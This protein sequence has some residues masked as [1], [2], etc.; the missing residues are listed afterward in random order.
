MRAALDRIVQR[1]SVHKC[2]VCHAVTYRKATLCGECLE[3]YTAERFTECRFCKMTAPVCV[4]STR[5]LYFCREL[6]LTM[7]SMFFYA[8]ENPTVKALIMSL[9]YA[10]DDEAE[11][12]LSR[13][14]AREILGIFAKRKEAACEWRVT[15]PP[16]STSGLLRHGKDHAKRMARALAKYT[17]MK[18]SPSFRHRGR[19]EQ[20]KLGAAA[21]FANAKESFTLKRDADVRGAKYVIVDDVVT[22]GATMRACQTLLLSNGAKCAFVLSVAKT[23]MRGAGADMRRR[24]HGRKVRREVA[25]DN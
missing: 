20:K 15:Y 14:L 10:P 24:F 17:G 9:K 5:E 1:L 3:K 22:S 23:P 21:R 19:S 2:P 6:D 7:R 13:E 11:I 8:S 18:F 16:R 4:C 25:K 12:F